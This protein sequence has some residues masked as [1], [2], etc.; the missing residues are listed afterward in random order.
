MCSAFLRAVL[1]SALVSLAVPA[2]AAC[3]PGALGTHRTIEL[4]PAKYRKVRGPEKR[5]GLRPKEVILSFDDGPL[6]GK[7]TRIL[8]ILKRDCVKATFFWV[9]RMARAYPKVV[10]RAVRE[11]HT[12]AHHTANHERL[13][14]YSSREGG[15]R[16]DRGIV[17]VERAAYGKGHRG[18]KVPYFRYPYLARNRRTDRILEKR[19]LINVSANILSNDWRRHSPQRILN[20]IMRQLRR[21]G[22]GIILM[23]DIH[24]R[25]VKTVPLLLKRLKREGYRIVHLAPPGGARPVETPFSD[26]DLVA[27]LRPIDGVVPGGSTVRLA[28]LPASRP[29]GES[30]RARSGVVMLPGIDRPILASTNTIAP[31]PAPA[32]RPSAPAAP[33]AMASLEPKAAPPAIYRAADAAPPTPGRVAVASLVPVALPSNAVALE[34]AP[35]RPRT[36][37]GQA[38]AQSSGDAV[39]RRKRIRPR[40]GAVSRKT[41]KAGKSRIGQRWKLRR[42]R[43]IIN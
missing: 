43:W 14:S 18:T 8:D 12:I 40:T 25:T 37:A 32:A 39:K 29:A 10:R 30:D 36:T 23:H 26:A 41:R 19:G 31:P 7:S 9:G 4:D 13:P 42:S 3:A 16:I 27:S 38:R 21:D 15:K 28:S 24:A 35:A 33:V 20:R 6:P 1:A 17:Q 5:L 11:G 2:F 34:A 22:R